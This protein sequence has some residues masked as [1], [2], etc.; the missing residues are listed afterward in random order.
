MDYCLLQGFNSLCKHHMKTTC[1]DI[2]SETIFVKEGILKHLGVKRKGLLLQ[3]KSQI[4]GI[5]S[6]SCRHEAAQVSQPV[7]HQISSVLEILEYMLTIL[8]MSAGKMSVIIR[9]QNLPWSANALDIRQY[10]RGLS[11]PEGGV[12]IVGGEQGDAF[13]AF[14]K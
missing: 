4:F 1:P 10:F 11:I 3:Q 13:I 5:I 2:S 12:H 6:Y 8:N 7:I 14:R 9:L